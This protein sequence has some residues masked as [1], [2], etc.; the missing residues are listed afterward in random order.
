MTS[1]NSNSS[2]D[3]SNYLAR[4]SAV[5]ATQAMVS[6]TQ[7][8][9]TQ[10]GLDILKRGGNAAD[11]AVAVAAALNVTEPMSTGIGGDLFCLY[12]DASTKEVRGLNGSGR[13]PSALTLRRALEEFGLK[14][15]NV[16]LSSVHAVTVP[17]AAAGWIDVVKTFGSN[18]L[19][20]ADILQPAIDLA[21][22]GI[23][24]TEITAKFWASLERKLVAANGP[25]GGGF[26]VSDDDGKTY[27]APREGEIFQNPALAETFR[28]VAK[29]G[30]SGFYK[31]RIAEAIVE[32]SQ[33]RGGV[34]QLQDLANQTSTLTVP[35]SIVYEGVRLFNPPPNS[36]GITAQ[37]ALSIL[38][39][40]QRA[41]SIP[42]LK[43]LGHNSA[44]Y[45]HA[46]IESLRIAFA[47]T[48]W[49]VT[50][51]AQVDSPKCAE[52]LLDQDYLAQRAKLFNPHKATID[53]EHGSPFA[54]S[55]T[56]LFSVVDQ[57]GNACSFV[58][59]NFTGFGSCIVPKGTGFAL[60]NRG[61]G[62]SLNPESPNRLE[63]SK[64][65]FHT[66]VCPMATRA[67]ASVHGEEDSLLYCFGNMGGYAQ[68]QS[69]LQLVLNLET[70]GMNPQLAV[71]APRVVIAPMIE[72]GLVVVDDR[73]DAQVIA[74]LRALGHKI[75]IAEGL[76]A[77]GEFGRGQIIKSSTDPRTGKRVLSAGSDSR[78]DGQAAGF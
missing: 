9:A 39:I 23:P 21:E 66:L 70:F 45:L 76:V 32:A 37:I 47:D 69:Q 60:Q 71:D 25:D 10:V 4:R 31:G 58:N 41:G 73:L 61:A 75:E 12:Y 43:E 1:I 22:D 40:L 49:F 24:V 44:A 13:S 46:V 6:C 52:R 17:G 50:D 62:F 27:R 16:P 51:P 63:P 68:P 64:R 67:V 74:E 59:S 57:Q 35:T 65:P 36:Q 7:P 48:R 3:R 34:M 78:A 53:V 29:D 19:C 18:K 38:D 30:W 8:L 72:E 14:G 15:A 56:V 28:T 55:D 11:A 26:L 20:M 33:A 42:P 2:S 77:L 5:H 54:S